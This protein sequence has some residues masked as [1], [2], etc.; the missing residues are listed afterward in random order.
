MT[1]ALITAVVAAYAAIVSTLSLILAV[2]VYRAANPKVEVDWVYSRADRNLTL[3]LLNT[4][5]SDVT[6]A[7][8]DLY[9]ER[10]VITSRNPD[11]RS[12]HARTD[13]ISHVPTELWL[14]KPKAV[15]HA[16]LAAHSMLSVQVKGDAISL[17]SQYPLDELRLKFVARFPG[18][19]ESA[20][21][22]GEVLCHFLGINPQHTYH[23]SSAGSL[24][25]EDGA[26]P[27]RLDGR[28]GCR[29]HATISD[30]PSLH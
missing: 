12:F 23:L 9:I 15:T 4:G 2:N 5:R 22:R 21:L 28:I 6:I 18:G 17:P 24:P 3:T 11:S 30:Q 20:G 27:T 8:V 14:R 29:V 19:K 1:P 26:E 16:R 13:T 10:H 7:T 25:S